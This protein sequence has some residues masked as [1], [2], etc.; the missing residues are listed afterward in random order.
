MADR[1]LKIAQLETES[2]ETHVAV[3]YERY[4]NTAD[5]LERLESLIEKNA[6]E[7]KEGFQELKKLVVW[8]ASTL[9]T[10]MLI[11]LLTSVFKVLG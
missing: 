2:L 4:K 8:S 1:D 5:S 10:T 6:N 7:T 9:F 11:A 3:C